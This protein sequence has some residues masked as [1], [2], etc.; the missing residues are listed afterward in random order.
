[1]IS[2]FWYTPNLGS[3]TLGNYPPAFFQ[4]M[5]ELH[6]AALLACRNPPSEMRMTFLSPGL[7]K[8]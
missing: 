5:K 4:V 7:E 3:M 1:M 6:I 8:K 2:L